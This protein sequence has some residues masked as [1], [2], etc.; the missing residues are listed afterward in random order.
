MGKLQIHLFGNLRVF[1]GDQQLP[2]PQ[3][4]KLTSVLSYLLLHREQLIPRDEIAFSIWTSESEADAR[5]NLRRHLHLLRRYLPP[6]SP[7]NPWL[8]S[9][10]DTTQWNLRSDYFLDVQAFEEVTN[11]APNRIPAPRAEEEITRLQSAAAYYEADLLENQYDDWIIAERERLYRR[12]I[13]TL[14]RLTMLQESLGDL[15]GAI[16]TSERL[17]ARDRLREENY[18]IIMRL[19]Y[20]AGDRAAALCHFE[21]CSTLLR[22]ELGV[23]PMPETLSLRDA[24]VS[25]K[26][27]AP[28]RPTSS[29]PI[30]APSQKIATVSP[31]ATPHATVAAAKSKRISI[32]KR[33]VALGILALAT[34]VGGIAIFTDLLTPAE[35]KAITGDT[36]TQDTW[37]TVERPDALFD[38]AYPDDWFK[39]Y[40]QVHLQFY[41]RDLDRYLIRFD[42]GSLPVNAKIERAELRVHLE[43]WTAEEGR[44]ALQRAYPAT[45]AAYR[46]RHPWQLDSATYIAPWMSPGLASGV[47]Y[48]AQPLATQTISGTTWLALDVTTAVRDWIVSPESNRGMMLKIVGAPEGV[49]HYWVDTADHSTPARRPQLLI[50]Y[51]KPTARSSPK[52]MTLTDAEIADTWITSGL[53]NATSAASLRGQ[54]VSQVTWVTEAYKGLASADKDVLEIPFERFPRARLNK[55]GQTVSHILFLCDLSRIPPSAQVDQAL[56]TV[57]LEPASVSLPLLPPTESH[58]F[59]A[60]ISVYR[61]LRAWL[62]S[63]VTYSSPWKES[64]LAAGVDYD[65]KPLATRRI[66]GATWLTFDIT[67]AVQAWHG[68]ANYGLMLALDEATEGIAPFWMPTIDHPAAKFHPEFRIIFS[69][70]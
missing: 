10:H 24:I 18:R 5:A 4:A 37:I 31:D 45:I 22:E 25:G 54:P 49:A 15:R 51:K 9:E 16:T 14:E 8:F 27:L 62:P 59:P 2:P 53:A 21:K 1:Y 6:T 20:Q 58:N 70:D 47:D 69:S 32:S 38:P 19:S 63:T 50:T 36:V 42:T 56:L 26:V 68:G 40:S 30:P 60:T 39:D 11:D 67:S 44:H 17:L 57:F 65:G 33:M 35:T 48:D 3:P 43:T 52:T 23:E 55:A 66:R 7:E 13:R 61:L 29:I 64:G 41:D 28:S 46:I 12:M 34:L